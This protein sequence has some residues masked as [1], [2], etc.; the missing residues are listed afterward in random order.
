MP[1]L[2]VDI[3]L[4]YVPIEDRKVSLAQ[5]VAALERIVENLVSVSPRIDCPQSSGNWKTS[6]ECLIANMKM[7]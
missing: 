2:S 6:E 7:R 4:V 1:R 3:D 5:A